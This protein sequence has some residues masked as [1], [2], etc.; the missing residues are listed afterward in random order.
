MTS[1]DVRALLQT[2]VFA[3]EEQA[4]YVDALPRLREAQERMARRRGYAF[5]VALIGLAIAVQLLPH[6]ALAET[7]CAP[8]GCVAQAAAG[9]PIAA[10]YAGQQRG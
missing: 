10:P 9:A 2:A 3:A 7:T 6:P 1:L 4:P 5:S 8:A